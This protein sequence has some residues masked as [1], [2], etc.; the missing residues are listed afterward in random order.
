[1]IINNNKEFKTA[2]DIKDLLDYTIDRLE[3]KQQDYISVDSLKNI[4]D[5]ISED[6]N[7]YSEEQ[8]SK[9]EDLKVG[10]IIRITLSDGISYYQQDYY[11]IKRISLTTIEA[12]LISVMVGDY[13]NS[14]KKEIDKKVKI[15]DFIK[16]YNRC[17]HK[18]ID[19]HKEWRNLE[20]YLEKMPFKKN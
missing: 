6:L 11:L 5:K 1:M 8:K 14:I 19:D 3:G 10:N 17:Y 18:L 2:L 12:D 20:S 9:C 13:E 16:M 7:K 15:D 4:R